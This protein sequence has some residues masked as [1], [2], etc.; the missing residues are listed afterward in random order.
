MQSFVFVTWHIPTVAEMPRKLSHHHD[1]KL[2]T[3]ITSTRNL[4]LTK[5]HHHVDLPCPLFQAFHACIVSNLNADLRCPLFQAVD[6]CIVSN[7]NRIQTYV[8]P[9]FK[10]SMRVQLVI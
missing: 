5:G 8:A 4:E 10:L 9:C 2:T 3:R 1:M 7:L 6:A